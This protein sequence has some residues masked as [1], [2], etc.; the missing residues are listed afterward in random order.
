MVAYYIFF[1]LCWSA[2]AALLGAVFLGFRLI[3]REKPE[4]PSEPKL[5]RT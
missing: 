3:L 4:K 1:V 5:P 2:A